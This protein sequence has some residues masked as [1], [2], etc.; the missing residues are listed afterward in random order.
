MTKSIFIAGT[1]TDVGKTFISK[2]ILQRAA[3]LGL[4]TAAYKPVSAG[5]DVT[6]EGLRNKDALTLQRYSTVNLVYE[7]VNPI[8]Y[9]DPVA[10]HLAA[11]HLD[12]VIDFDT[13]T[14]G[15]E[16][17]QITQAD[18]I[19]VEGAG[20]WRLPLGQ[21]RFLSDVVKQ[22]K[23]PVVLVVGM[24][25]G[26]LNHALLTVEAIERDGVELIGWIANQIDPKMAYYEQNIGALTELIS[27]PNLGV[28][29]FVD[30]DSSN[31]D[32]SAFI[33]FP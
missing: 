31:V 8:A 26:C 32:V 22:Q 19:L 24:K 30:D 27:A 21:G 13:V 1:D 12:E 9:A 6:V 16:K 7:D 15:Y 5:C 14:K 33:S 23:I 20:G 28:V 4:S 11:Q 2:A 17:L 3:K 10:P 29:P 18:L 25:L